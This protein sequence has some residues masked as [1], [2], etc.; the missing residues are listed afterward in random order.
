MYIYKFEH[1]KLYIQ[2]YCLTRKANEMKGTR[3]QTD[4]Y[5]TIRGHPQMSPTWGSVDK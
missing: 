1:T 5:E 3:E 4:Y 2:N